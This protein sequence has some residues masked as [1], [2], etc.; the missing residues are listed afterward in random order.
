MA[1]ENTYVTI[2]WGDGTNDSYYL[3]FERFDSEGYIMV[4]SDKNSSNKLRS[5]T[6]EFVATDSNGNPT[7]NKATLLVQQAVNN[8]LTA[9]FQMG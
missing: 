2:K 6:L 4:S 3:S 1:N 9:T 5:N 8:S 7:S